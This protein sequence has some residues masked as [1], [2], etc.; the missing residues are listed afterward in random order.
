[1][2]F[3]SIS[4]PPQITTDPKGKQNISAVLLEEIALFI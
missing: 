1:M 3:S 2:T 4:D